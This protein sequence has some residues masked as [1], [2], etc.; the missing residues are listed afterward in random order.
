MN[1]LLIFELFI[2]ELLR[3]ELFKFELEFCQGLFIKFALV[4]GG[5]GFTFPRTLPNPLFGK[6]PW[7][8]K[9][10]VK[11]LLKF[12]VCIGLTFY[13]PFLKGHILQ[14]GEGNSM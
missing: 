8:G 4:T 7:L 13:K 5:N 11:L 1:E 12:V 9:L 6:S 14:S 10:F 3:F 2:F